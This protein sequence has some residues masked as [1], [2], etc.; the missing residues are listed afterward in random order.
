MLLIFNRILIRFMYNSLSQVEDSV[1]TNPTN[2]DLH[3][4]QAY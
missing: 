2:G 1:R 3:S 4:T